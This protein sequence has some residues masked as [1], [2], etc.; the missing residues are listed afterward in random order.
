M[1]KLMRVMLAM[2]LLCG[3]Q[4]AAAQSWT[5]GE[6]PR[7]WS[8]NV[9]GNGS[10]DQGGVPPAFLTMPAD[11]PSE[12]DTS[13][14]TTISGTELPDAKTAAQGGAEAK[15]RFDCNFTGTGTFDPILYPGQAVAGHPHTFVG[16]NWIVNNPT[17][18]NYQTL[19]ANGGA[20]CYGGKLNRTAYWEPTVYKNVNG[21]TV[22][23]KPHNLITYY[24]C[25]EINPNAAGHGSPRTCTVWPRGLNFVAGFNL[26]DPTGSKYTA[27][28]AASP[29]YGPNGP[30]NGRGSWNCDVPNS[31]NGSVATSPN[32]G[33]PSQPWLRNA[34]GTP[35]LDCKPNTE[36]IWQVVANT[37]WDGK[38]LSSPNGRD[39][40]SDVARKNSDNTLR[41]P[42]GWY[43]TVGF[44]VFVKFWQTGQSDYTNWWVASDRMGTNQ[45]NWYR[46]GES[47]HFD[48]IP[49]W[50]Y[51]TTSNPGAFL[52]FVNRCLG[53][54]ID[55]GTGPVMPAQTPRECGFAAM[56][57]YER[58]VTGASPDG[59]QPN[60]VVNLNLDHSGYRRYI[61]LKA[62]TNLM[63]ATIHDK[64]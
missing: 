63:G 15:A 16:N 64:H 24:A 28:L 14:W 4:T 42:D 20:N 40:M 60:P 36:I 37:C 23:I 11:V 33:S 58:A 43:H 57:P 54:R 5:V 46:N 56:G 25:G 2:L 53:A 49:A 35:T 50:D 27:A 10:N 1:E 21:L 34:D 61:P 8:T 12:F 18:T 31:G 48:L 39:H 13:Q 29:G 32:P 59:S 52:R 55:L 7:V 41:C 26:F 47:M 6:Q 38:N 51:G 45:A 22:G 44:A 3:V 9:L 19:R 17:T 62:N 30:A